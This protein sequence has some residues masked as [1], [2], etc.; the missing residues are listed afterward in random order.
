MTV[1]TSANP[2]STV[3]GTSRAAAT[4]IATSGTR[5]FPVRWRFRASELERLARDGGALLAALAPAVAPGGLLVHLTCS[6]EAE[7]NEQVL[8]RFLAANP[9]FE[10]LELDGRESWV[11]AGSRESGRWRVLPGAGHDGFSVGV[12]RRRS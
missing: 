10:P 8:D 5:A 1:R 7:E 3:G 6:V 11:A 2:S 12:V 9:A 4:W